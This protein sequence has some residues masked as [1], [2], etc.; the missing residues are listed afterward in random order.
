MPRPVRTYTITVERSGPLA[1]VQVFKS[2][3]RESAQFWL[4]MRDG[5]IERGRNRI[6]LYAT[7]F[8]VR[9]FVTIHREA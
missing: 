8:G 5:R 2:A 4:A 3:P 9:A 7:L 6:R 1:K